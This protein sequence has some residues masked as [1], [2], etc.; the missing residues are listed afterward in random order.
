MK[1]SPC[2][3]STPSWEEGSTQHPPCSV[4]WLLKRIAV[5]DS[6]LWFL[7]SGFRM[8]LVHPQKCAANWMSI[9]EDGYVAGTLTVGAWFLCKL[10]LQH[11]KQA[12]FLL[13]FV[14]ASGPP[15]YP[16]IRSLLSSAAHNQ[17]PDGSRPSSS[18]D[19]RVCI[20]NARRIVMACQWCV[21]NY[22][23]ISSQF[24]VNDI[25]EKIQNNANET[26][27]K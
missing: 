15:P 19:W 12:I 21:F 14:N 16:L 1:D 27:N 2:T 3:T 6:G 20:S 4:D 26:P 22:T 10:M 7:V 23:W 11:S 17:I 8:L 9:C 24:H 13:H 25:K 18:L 5:E